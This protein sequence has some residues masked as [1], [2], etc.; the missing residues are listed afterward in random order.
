VN[1]KGC[2][3]SWLHQPSNIRASSRLNEWCGIL[4]SE[5]SLYTATFGLTSSRFPTIHLS[6][7]NS[8]ITSNFGKSSMRFHPQPLV[9]TV[10]TVAVAL[11]WLA[12]WPVQGG[13]IVTTFRVVSIP[14]YQNLWS[15][16]FLGVARSN[17][18]PFLSKHH[19]NN[20]RSSGTAAETT[21]G[22][23][24]QFAIIARVSGSSRA[25]SNFGSSAS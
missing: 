8:I 1:H 22:L 19:R 13:E 12:G 6:K 9:I 23:M 14:C 5:P 3:R 17:R 18:R 7:S 16:N 25:L 24:N 15:R 10:V 4:L 11:P 2:L 21:V 20:C